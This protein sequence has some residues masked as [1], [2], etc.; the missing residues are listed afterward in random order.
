METS[1]A[2]ELMSDEEWAFNERFIFLAVRA[3]NGRK[4]ANYRLVLDRADQL[5]LA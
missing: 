3:P 2:R 4:P 5:F 1:L